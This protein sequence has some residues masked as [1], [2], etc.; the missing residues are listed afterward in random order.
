MME[1]KMMYGRM[2]R[3]NEMPAAFMASNSSFS[4][5]LPKVIRDDN[6]M[7]SGKA[8]ETNDKAA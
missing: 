1:M 6:R 8:M 3:N 2:M 5:K 4:P 7:D